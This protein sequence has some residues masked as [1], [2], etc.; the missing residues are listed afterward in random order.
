[1]KI[2][3]FN[4]VSKDRKREGCRK[5]CNKSLSDCIYSQMMFTNPEA[6]FEL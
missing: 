1:M 2:I 5:T 6:E 3:L 4:I